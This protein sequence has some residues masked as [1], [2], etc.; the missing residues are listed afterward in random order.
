MA[1]E[2]AVNYAVNPKALAGISGSFRK[3]STF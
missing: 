1:V 3:T 2:K